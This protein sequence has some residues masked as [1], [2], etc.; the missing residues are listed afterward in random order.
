ML[1]GIAVMLCFVVLVGITK[2]KLIRDSLKE[3]KESLQ[4]VLNSKNSNTVAS[5]P[6]QGTAKAKT[7]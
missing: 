4:W 6:A 3:L 1:H 2:A 7:D 5:V